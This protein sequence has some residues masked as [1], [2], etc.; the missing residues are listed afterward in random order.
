VQDQLP[1]VGTFV[2]EFGCE[3]IFVGNLHNDL[4]YPAMFIV[5]YVL[6]TTA[7]RS[8]GFETLG[9]TGSG[10]SEILSLHK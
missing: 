7:S 2:V 3:K 5:H 6:R 4:N 1:T 8:I 10:R 9:N